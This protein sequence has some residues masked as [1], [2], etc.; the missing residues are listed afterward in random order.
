MIENDIKRLSRLAAILTQMQVRRLLNATMLAEKFGVSKRTIYRD[1]K[2][3]EQAG[4]PIITEEGKGYSLVDG[5]RLPPVMFTENEAYALVT[6]EQIIQNNRDASFTKDF[7]DALSKIKSVLNYAIKDKADILASRV[8]VKSN[9]EKERVSN[10]LSEL[11]VA[12]TNFNLVTIEYQPT[13]EVKA[14]K[15]VIEPF[16]L[17]HSAEENWLIIAHCRLKNDYRSFRLDRIKKLSVQNESFNPHKI[18][19]GQYFEKFKDSI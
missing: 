15:R 10:Y 16:F 7:S 11:Q 1:I 9:Y 12:L 3:L 17:Y 8:V 5:Y 2:A 6:A 19:V 4:V 18:S 14:T 13:T